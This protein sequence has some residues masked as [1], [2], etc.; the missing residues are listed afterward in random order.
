MDTG[1]EKL[2]AH[3]IEEFSKIDVKKTGAISIT[4]IK[5][6]LFNSKYTNLTP[7]QVFTLIGM[8]QPD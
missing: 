6:V 3:L 5:K 8:S 7:F 2:T 4:D 1:I